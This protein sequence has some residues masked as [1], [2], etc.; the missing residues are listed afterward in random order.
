MM[1]TIENDLLKVVINSL[2]AELNSLFSKRNGHEFM[3][4]GDPKF[5][6]KRSPALFPIVGTLKNNSYSTNGKS[7]ELGRHGFAREKVFTVTNQTATSISFELKSDEQTLSVYPFQFSF[8]LIYTIKGNN[9]SVTYLVKNNGGDEMLFSVG[10]HP[11]FK[12]PIADEVAYEDY[13]LL[14]NKTEN[15]GRWPISAAGLIDS[16]PIALLENTNRLPLT[17]SLFYKD[18]IVLKNL[19]SDSVE[20]KSDKDPVGFTFSFKGFPYLGIWAAKDADFVC[21]EP[22][23]G[24]ADSVNSNQVL[25]DKEGIM[26]LAA[27]EVFKR[28]WGISV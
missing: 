19:A 7:Y 1:N 22:W 20:L 11:A 12:L 26:K 6:P 17:K 9:L 25:G 14:F 13:Y 4:N 5:W 15:A 2:G 23:C 16:V 10:A 21:I 24:I 3:W 28:S 18:A 8:S 27:G